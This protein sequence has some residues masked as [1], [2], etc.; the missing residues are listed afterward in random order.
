M[1]NKNKSDLLAD[2]TKK[3]KQN[4]FCEHHLQEYK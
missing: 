4:L 3:Q 2:T 1:K